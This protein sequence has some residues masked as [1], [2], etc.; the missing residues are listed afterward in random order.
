MGAQRAPAARRWGE[1]TTPS[2]C[3]S[4]GTG[5]WRRSTGKLGGTRVKRRYPS[6]WSRRGRS[7]P[8]GGV[9][10]GQGAHRR[11]ARATTCAGRHARVGDDLA[12][13]ARRP[14]RRRD[15]AVGGARCGPHGPAPAIEQRP[16]GDSPRCAQR[17]P[18]GGSRHLVDGWRHPGGPGGAE[19][20]RPRPVARPAGSSPTEQGPNCR[21]GLQGHVPRAPRR[22]F[23]AGRAPLPGALLMRP[24]LYSTCSRARSPAA[25]SCSGRSTGRRVSSACST[26]AARRSPA[27]CSCRW[28][29]KPDGNELI[30]PDA[31]ARAPGAVGL[32]GSRRRRRQRRRRAPGR[33][34]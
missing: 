27:A 26:P 7:S 4:I 10:S 13:T 23:P 25:V 8:P 14:R 33:R 17:R 31:L 19:G 12:W 16:G 29:A 20:S 2:G 9:V 24:P 34:L 22:P 28:R 6:C 30:D 5:A 1:P 11:G 3:W 18:P 32:G 15:P 21:W